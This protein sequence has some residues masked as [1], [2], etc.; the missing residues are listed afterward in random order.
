LSRERKKKEAAEPKRK[1]A[2]KQEEGSELERKRA[3]KREE[4][5]EPKRK[6]APKQEEGS[7]LKRKRAPKREEIGEP[8]RKRAPKQEEGS[9]LKRKRAPKREEIGE[10]KRK[11][12]P[13]Q[14]EG[15]ELKRKRAPKREE[16]G[17]PKR[18]RA[19]KR[20]EV[21]ELKRKKAPKQQELEDITEITNEG[22]LESEQPVPDQKGVIKQGTIAEFM[23]KRTQLVG[24]DMGLYK[25]TQYMAEFMDNSL[26]AIEINYWKDPKTYQLKEDFYF[27]Y[28]KPK[29]LLKDIEITQENVIDLMQDLLAPLKDIINTEPLLVI[30]IQEIEKP[31]MLSEDQSGRDIRM[32]SFECFDTGIGLVPTDLEKF[33]KYLASSKAEQLKQTRGSQGFGASSAFSDA[34][35]TTGRPI[36]VISR[37][38]GAEKAELTSFFTTSKN[39]KDY[40]IKPTEIDVPFQ[41]GTYVRLNYL[42]VKYKRGYADEY[43]VRTALL[44]SHVSL[45]FID[46]SGEVIIYPRRVT[47]FPNEPKYA[48]PHPA[49]SSIGDFKEMLRISEDS[50]I[51]SFLEQKYVRMSREKAKKIVETANQELG[52]FKG[53]LSKKPVELSPQEIQTLAKVLNKQKMCINRIAKADLKQLVSEA[54][55]KP[56]V[57][58]LVEKFPEISK[59][60]YG[61]IL[62]KLKLEKKTTDKITPEDLD[63]IHI[64]ILEDIK[65]PSKITLEAF[66]DLIIKSWD[67]TI[68]DILG[69]D[70]CK[71]NYN[72]VRK[73]LL[74][75][76][77]QLN[78]KS[79]NSIIAKDATEQELDI[80]Y[81]L[82][83]ATIESQ[84]ISN[85][86]DFVNLMQSGK[87]KSVSSVLQSIKGLG[88]NKAG[89]IIEKAD[90]KLQYKT[91]LTSKANE[92]SNKEVEAIY[93]AIQEL[94]KCS[95]AVSIENLEELLKSATEANL[96]TF[97]TRNLLDIDKTVA[98]QVIEETNNQ[99]GGFVSLES[100][101][102]R[103]L[104]EDQMNAL[105]KAFVSEKYLAPPT[106]TVV[107]V[108]SD[109]LERVIKKNYEP[110]FVVA[111]TRPP[112]SGKGL[113]YEVEVAIAYSGNIKEA[114][115]AADVLYR[116]VNRTPKLRDNSD[117]AIWKGVTRVNWKNYKIET[118][119]NNIPKGKL[120]I[121]V[122]VSGP[123]VHVMFKSQSKQALAE[124]DIL[125]R[126]IQL[127][128]ES[129]GRK[130]KSYVL[131][132]ETSKRRAKRALTL[133]KNVEKFAE[134]LYKV[135]CEDFTTKEHIPG[136]PTL[137]EI[138]ANLSKPIKEDLKPDVKAVLSEQWSTLTKIIEDLG[139]ES[140]RDKF[141]RNLITD[142]LNDLTSE[143]N[144]IEQASPEKITN[145]FKTQDDPNTEKLILDT[146]KNYAEPFSKCSSCEFA[147]TEPPCSFYNADAQVC[148]LEQEQYN[149]FVNYLKDTFKLD[150]VN[151]EILLQ[152][153]GLLDVQIGQNRRF[154]KP[155]ED[156][157]DRKS[158]FLDELKASSKEQKG[159]LRVK[160]NLSIVFSEIIKKEKEDLLW[161]LVK[162]D[163]KKVI[164][165]N[166]FTL[167]DI[168]NMEFPNIKGG[169]LSQRDDFVSEFVQSAIEALID[170]G[171]LT[172]TKSEGKTLYQ[173]LKNQ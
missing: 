126:E 84:E 28:P 150:P 120:R 22:D 141:I 161:R 157:D 169:R 66:R 154:K 70:F 171:V 100:V 113:A 89:D 71:L 152:Y 105:Y 3:P 77:S 23:R 127:G 35:N 83:S 144:I 108:G 118:F 30:R 135:E 11:R 136:K 97:L 139:L 37:H 58:M 33:G 91:L 47:K 79:L 104:N 167:E 24:F 82:F 143:Y 90:I 164:P 160:T 87:N 101:A 119:D 146:L 42:N 54:E 134:S 158:A 36:T 40:T 74:T 50:S 156:L 38:I 117:C 46:P 64:T 48:K 163:I 132:R 2:P 49:S 110:H 39:E 32:F 130:L 67:R 81:Q 19:P 166:E 57:D 173:R 14:E 51:I 155:I 109:I 78:Y 147:G 20:E 7:E 26:D 29:E 95:G 1:R 15:S 93:K 145:I 55:A 149:S 75:V 123:F 21:S 9:G 138:E 25:H 27:E 137:E 121:F 73:I 98:D 116:F 61:Q 106:D 5:G 129:I 72:L 92:L 125:I 103:N 43:I 140:L 107:P 16:I 12:A 68:Y 112:T 4:V 128:L 96:S 8:K 172:N 94:E 111:E 17:E 52:G 142:V 133:L 76:D 124:D 88:K 53:L 168:L 41:H 115:K 69:K 62:K 59:P 56:I 102:P 34:Q 31:E 99:L 13:K 60:Q 148:A 44:N 151:D 85:K 65:C 162:P 6:R 114:S 63:L 170:E 86:E 159:I 80:L 122:N 165:E 18:K 10:L 131:G 45:M 153:L